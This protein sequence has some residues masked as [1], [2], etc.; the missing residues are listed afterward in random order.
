MLI[1]LLLKKSVWLFRP[2]CGKALPSAIDNRGVAL[3]L[4]RYC[5]LYTAISGLSW[6]PKGKIRVLFHPHYLANKEVMRTTVT[7]HSIPFVTHHYLLSLLF[8][9]CFK[10]KKRFLDKTV[11]RMWLI[12]CVSSLL[13][14]I[15]FVLHIER[16]KSHFPFL[17]R[18]FAE[19]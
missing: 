4:S 19:G 9:I 14:Y 18:S 3:A 11:R 10:T 8:F 15:L 6:K 1:M 13:I 5:C 2:I 16:L 17:S 12:K 7:L